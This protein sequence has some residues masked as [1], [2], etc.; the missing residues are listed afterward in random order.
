MFTE[1]ILIYKKG[2]TIVHK[3]NPKT[4]MFYAFLFIFLALLSTNIYYMI[5]LFFISILSIGISKMIREWLKSLKAIWFFIV[6]VLIFNYLSTFNIEFSISMVLRLMIFVNAFMVFIRTTPLEDLA[7]AL[8]ELG[9]PY[10]IVLAFTMSLR[11]IPT[12]I[13]DA[14]SVID[15]QRAR[16]LET[17]K[18]NPIKRARNYLPVLIP[19]IVLS[20]RRAQQVAEAMEAR[21]F[22]ASKR[23]SSLYQ[24]KTTT[25]DY[26]T[27]ILLLIFSFIMSVWALGILKF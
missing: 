18:G 19:L 25:L 13:R 23:P 4:K 11:F 20:I 7:Q 1:E 8:Y 10:D 24:I 27:A 6:I 15:A 5:T 2:S 3:L 26:V 21:A 16:G 9:I 17:Q 22:G 12:I 14:Q